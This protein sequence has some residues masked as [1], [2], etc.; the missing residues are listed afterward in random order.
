MTRVITGMRGYPTNVTDIK[1]TMRNGMNNFM[2][3]NLTI[4]AK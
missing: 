1:W 3:I 4:Q 2:T